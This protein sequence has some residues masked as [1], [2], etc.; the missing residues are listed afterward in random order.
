M[1]IAQKSLAI[2]A[3]AAIAVAVVF[4]FYSTMQVAQAATLSQTQIQAII[5]LLQSFG[6]DPATIANVQASLNGQATTGTGSVNSSACPYTWATNLTVG[7]TGADVLALQ[8][9]LNADSAT[10][11]SAI[12]AGSPGMET[13]FFGPATKAAVIK[14]QNKYASEILVPVGLTAGTGFFGSSSRAKANELCSAGSTGGGTTGGGTTTTGTGLTVSA[15]V[16]PAN[17]LAPQGASRVPFTRFT[18]TAGNDGDVT[19]NSVTVQ[20]TGLG[21]DAAFAGVVLIDESTGIQ[22]GTAKTF[23]SNHQTNV[24]AVMTV[25]RGTS[26]SF[27]IAGNM[28]SSL[29]A[30]TGQAPS[31]AVVAINTSA[32]VTGSLPITGASQTLNSTLSVGTLTLNTS[33]AYATNS[34]SSQS[35]GTTGFRFT[36]FRVTAGSAEDVRLRSVTWNQTGSVSSTDLANVVTVVNGTSYPTMVSADGKYYYTNLG[37]GVVIT[38]GNSADIY[39]QGDIVGSNS[40]GRTAI[41]DVDKNTDIF[42]TGETYGYGIS[43]ALGANPPSGT[44]LNLEVTNGTPYIYAAQIS[45]TGASV[46]TISK[47]NEVPSQNIAI[48]VANQPLGGFA[49]DIRGE[50]LSVQT[51]VF[52]V[53]TTSGARALTN[54]TLV[55]ENGSVVAG[56]VDSVYVSS[57]ASTVTFT[58]TVTI[59][60][61]RHVYTLRGKVASDSSNNG[62]YVL[63]TTPSSWG[64]VKGET[65]GNSVSLSGMGAFA[66]NTMTVQAGTVA[67]GVATSPASQT[68]VPGGSGVLIANFQFDASQSGEDVRFASIPTTLTFS[69]TAGTPSS[70][71]DL[72]SC[73]FYNGSMPLNSGSNV[74]QPSNATATT[75][76][77]SVTVPLDN[78]VTVAKGTVLTVGLRCNISGSAINTA[79]YKFAPQAAANF[80]FSGATS[81]TTIVGT[82]ASSPSIVVTIGAG[83]AT[84]SGDSSAPSY[85]IAAAGSTGVV[86]NAIK[87]HATN[88]DIILQKLGLTLTNTASSSSSDLVK[89]TIWDG[90]N[91]VGEAFFAGS[92]SFATSTLTQT[93]TIPKNSDKVLT[94]AVDLAPIGI[95][96]AVAFSGHLVAVDYLNAQAVGA[97]SGSTFN[98]GSAAG[99]TSASGIRVMESFPI[100]SVDSTS[101]LS[102]GVADGRLMRFKVT[103]DNTNPSGVG[104][105]QFVLNFATTTVSVTNIDIRA[106]THSDY[107]SPVSGVST[108]GSLKATAVTAANGS[109]NATIP[110]QTSGAVATALQIPR[111]TTYYF[112]VYGSVAGDATGASVTTKLLGDSSFPSTGALVTQNPL[113]QAASLS[114]NLIW[115]PNST[116]T[117]ARTDQ[118]W[119][120]GYGVSGLPAGGLFYTRSH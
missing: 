61:G 3:T 80:S 93:V 33:N 79:T 23:N 105:T 70:K 2:I 99:S 115:S 14:F 75:S 64:N 17:S 60:T 101:L 16:Q 28:A 7:S 48:N 72:S 65:S 42:A 25:P 8:K 74:L 94:V 91:K 82:D 107:T 98:L 106:F 117:A 68:Q 67:V 103:A 10:Q 53:A 24:G 29:S 69:P 22:L 116:T 45:V 77:Y 1:S 54:V 46:T 90:A 88:E 95:G 34:N 57:S 32:N 110:V 114:T 40:S 35:V 62:T 4:S 63:S 9:F 41:F 120:G 52:N 30:Y 102:T 36:G 118:D 92:N 11:V 71:T 111:G 78:S 27:L 104:I 12:G 39:A 66:M 108:D 55:D 76:P 81:G 109:G 13:S 43:P 58:D 113:L 56:P 26:K 51:M 20:R 59:P 37:S 21:A 119:T 96:Q 112:E 31:I 83:S 86:A 85:V 47:A 89:A 5:S 87:F 84:V 44:R 6:A 50:G 100:F 73:Q 19:V 38:K 49:T 97:Q 15:G 18:L